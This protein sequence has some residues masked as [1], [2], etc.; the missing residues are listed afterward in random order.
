ML[1]EHD[2]NQAFIPP[3][4]EAPAAASVRPV[5]FFAKLWHHLHARFRFQCT[6]SSVSTT[7]MP[8]ESLEEVVVVSPDAT[9][10]EAGDGYG[11]FVDLEAP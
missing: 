3:L 7:S 8:D 5:A 1:H 10:A 6:L 11:W 4:A 9:E 2:H